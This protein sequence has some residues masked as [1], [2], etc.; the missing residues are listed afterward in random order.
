MD[1][2]TKKKSVIADSKNFVWREGSVKEKELLMLPLCNVSS[3]LS[4]TADVKKMEFDI[5][6]FVNAS[7]CEFADT[8]DKSTLPRVKSTSK[9]QVAATDNSKEATASLKDFVNASQSSSKPNK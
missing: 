8:H 4:L 6:A 7:V 9:D 3:H 5:E 2:T 1:I